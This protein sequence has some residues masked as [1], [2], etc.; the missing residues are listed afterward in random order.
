MSEEAYDENWWGTRSISYTYDDLF[1]LTQA[2]YQPEDRKENYAY[3]LNGNRLRK[4]VTIEGESI[5]DIRYRYNGLNQL[6]QAG[7]EIFYHDAKG[8]IKRRIFP[9]RETEYYWDDENRLVK[10]EENR[11]TRVEG[12][13]EKELVK[14]VE[15][16]HNGLGQR[17]KRI[18]TVVGE[19]SHTTEYVN[20]TGSAY[21]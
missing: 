15:Y 6:V 18:L 13:E 20:S 10:V 2:H 7:D 14:T 12:H 1:R 5:E 11:L 3:D 8:N 17:I 9:D 4:W 21:Q 19:E 16:V